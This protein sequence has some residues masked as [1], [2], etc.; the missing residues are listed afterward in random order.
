MKKDL[1][2]QKIKAAEELALSKM[3][4]DKFRQGYHLMPLSG[5]MNDPNG[6]CI[7]QVKIY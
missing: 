1:L 4:N 5:W 7:I 2:Y 3:N 6:L